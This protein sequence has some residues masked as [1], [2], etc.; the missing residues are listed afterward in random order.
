MVSLGMLDP[1]IDS[2]DVF[3]VVS[4]ILCKPGIFGLI[5]AALI[6]ALM[7]TADTLINAVSVIAVNDIYRPYI[8]KDAEDKHYLFIAR[9]VSVI[10]AIIGI[11]LVP[12][13]MGFKSIYA[14]HGAFT[15][16]MTPPIIVVIFLG[17]FWKRFTPQ[18]AFWTLLGGMMAI[19]VSLKFPVLIKPISHGVPGDD[20]YTYMRAL[21]GL[22]ASVSIGLVVT[23]F[24][25]PRSEE[26]IKG[27]IYSSIKDGKRI[28]KGGEPN[29]AP[30]EKLRLTPVLFESK[31]NERVVRI[32]ENDIKK[33]NGRPGDLVNVSDSRWWTGGLASANVKLGLPH[34][35]DDGVI[36][37][38]GN[39]FDSENLPKNRLLIMEKIF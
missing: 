24:S 9:I 29:D 18:A 34:D 12:V 7:S 4:E 27:L 32:S 17:A 31:E 10:T 28:F 16:M 22:I 1:N 26:S 13:Y 5:L 3:V 8:K 25:K 14:A 11:L 36:F 2:R 39:L 30:G 37:I 21:F 15:A 23:F 20:G 19:F 33:L 38:N 6:A 35:K